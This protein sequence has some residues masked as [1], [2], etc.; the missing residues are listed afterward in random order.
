MSDFGFSQYILQPICVFSLPP[1]QIDHVM[2]N[3]MIN[4]SV[5]NSSQVSDHTVQLVEFNIPTQPIDIDDHFTNVNGLSYI[6][7]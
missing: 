2:A 5:L 6:R 3:N 7:E 4:I 1:T